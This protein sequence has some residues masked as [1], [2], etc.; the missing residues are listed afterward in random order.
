M[1]SF[2]QGDAGRAPESHAGSHGNEAAQQ[3]VIEVGAALDLMQEH[4]GSFPDACAFPAS[5]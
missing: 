4:G 1:R 5:A 2:L 3:T